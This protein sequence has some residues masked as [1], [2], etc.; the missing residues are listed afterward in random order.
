MNKLYRNI[1]NLCI[2]TNGS[3][4]VGAEDEKKFVLK[5]Y[6]AVRQ[7]INELVIRN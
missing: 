2:K 3:I 6:Y 7:Y 1:L 4:L 5:I